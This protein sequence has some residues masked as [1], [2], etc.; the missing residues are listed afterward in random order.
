MGIKLEDLHAIFSQVSFV[1]V[2]A[3]DELL[4]VGGEKGDKLSLVDT[5]EDTKAEDPVAGL[6][7]RGDQV[8]ARQGDQHAARAGE[9]RRHPLLLRGPHARRDRP[10]P[11]R[12]REPHLP[13]AHQGRAAAARQAR[14][15]ARLT[16]RPSSRLQRR[17]RPADR[18][19]RRHH[20]HRV[21]AGSSQR[22]IRASRLGPTDTQ[23]AVAPGPLTCRKIPPPSRGVRRLVGDPLAVRRPVHAGRQVEVEHHRVAVLRAVARQVLGPGRA[24]ARRRPPGGAAARC[25]SRGSRGS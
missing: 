7:V 9:D 4:S 25:R 2:V 22:R 6:R 16:G 11:R 1:N 23:P 10:G 3:L 18:R 17:V 15:A 12:H 13:D 14:R 20:D 21:L 8:P 5:L 24:P 19:R